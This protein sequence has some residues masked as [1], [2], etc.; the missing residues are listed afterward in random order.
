MSLQELGA[1]ERSQAESHVDQ[2]Q[3]YDARTLSH[4]HVSGCHKMVVQICMTAAEQI[5]ALR[6]TYTAD[7]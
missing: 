4:I 1:L 7:F 5:E 2:R 6:S 3:Q